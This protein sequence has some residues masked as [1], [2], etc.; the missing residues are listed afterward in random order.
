MGKHILL[1]GLG[2]FI[3]SIARYVISTS[4]TKYFPLSFPLGTFVVNVSGCLVIGI[5]YG[6]TSRFGWMT[7]EWRIFLATGICGGFTTFS[8]FAYESLRLI[9]TSEYWTFVGY[10]ILS[11]FFCVLAVFFGVGLSKL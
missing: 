5:I 2:G 8:A 7:Q 1:V 11:L 3:G 6:L 10:T 9:E 4:I